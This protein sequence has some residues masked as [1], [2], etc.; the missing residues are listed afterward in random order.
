MKKQQF[1]LNIKF[2]HLLMGVIFFALIACTNQSWHLRN[3]A[4]V[5]PQ[6]KLIYLDPGN[7]NSR[8]TTELIHQ[9]K[10][11]QISLAAHPQNAP[12][13]LRVYQYSFQHNNPAISTTNVAITYTYT[14]SLMIEIIDNA[15]QVIVPPHMVSTSRDITVTTNQIFT[16]NSSTLFQQELQMDGI[17]MIYYWLTNDSTRRLLAASQEKNIH[18]IKPQ[19][20][21]SAP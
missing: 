18:A 17:N 6:L 13:I 3:A 20:T 19:T 12:L 21:S 14:L 16:I 7:A 11:M 4:A 10:S 2:Y 9:L 1:P 5:P 15:N 8:F